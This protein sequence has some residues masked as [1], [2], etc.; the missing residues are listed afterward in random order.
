MLTSIILSIFLLNSCTPKSPSTERKRQKSYSASSPANIVAN[1]NTTTTTNT[2]IDT[3]TDTN[4]IPT[5]SEFEADPSDENKVKCVVVTENS[6]KKMKETVT[7]N[8]NMT[9]TPVEDRKI[10]MY[11]PDWSI[12]RKKK[13]TGY[14]KYKDNYFHIKQIH[15]KVTHINYSFAHLVV[16]D[17]RNSFAENWYLRKKVVDY[18]NKDIAYCYDN[19]EDEK[20]KEGGDLFWATRDNQIATI[21]KAM[22]DGDCFF[23]DKYAAVELACKS[24]GEIRSDACDENTVYETTTSGEKIKGIIGELHKWRKKKTT[25]KILV[26]IGGWTL[27]R[28][29]AE[30]ASAGKRASVASSC[31]NFIKKYK[32]DGIDLDWEFPISGGNSADYEIN[33]ASTEEEKNA[34]RAIMPMLHRTA[35]NETQGDNDYINF[36]EFVKELRQALGSEYLLTLAGPPSLRPPKSELSK[37]SDIQNFK[38]RLNVKA[39]SEH[40]DFINMMNYDY[41][42][43]F[44]DRAAHHSSLFEDVNNP[45]NSSYNV[46][47]MINDYLA[48]GAPANKL[49]MGVPLYGRGIKVKKLAPSNGLYQEK[50]AMEKEHDSVPDQFGTWETGTYDYWHIKEMLDTKVVKISPPL[51]GI[52]SPFAF[53][54]SE[55]ILIGYDNEASL[56]EKIE[57][58]LAKG[59]SGVM[60]WDFYGDDKTLSIQKSIANNISMTIDPNSPIVKKCRWQKPIYNPGG[61]GGAAADTGVKKCE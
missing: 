4:N 8:P 16:G 47:N 60:L 46:N 14:E 22:E 1:T 40:V 10:V 58:A 55:K 32:L 28:F 18:H 21:N 9:P 12:Y 3:N 17:A 59:I 25:R 15:E 33:A 56:K 23:I 54:E 26:S 51:N 11:V 5:P 2:N 44:S 49:V 57:C 41:F 35:S 36:V 13:I 52:S 7:D 30:A 27:S 50:D 34:V 31:A 6:L 19:E 61:S 24:D 20:C 53:N 43:H 39:L 48:L 45:I 29:F 42:G 38:A 37:N